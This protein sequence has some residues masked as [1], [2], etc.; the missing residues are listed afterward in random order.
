MA[1]EVVHTNHKTHKTESDQPRVIVESSLEE[2]YDDVVCIQWRGYLDNEDRELPKDIGQFH[3]P[4]RTYPKDARWFGQP[5][6]FQVAFVGQIKDWPNQE[7]IPA[8]M[9]AY[10]LNEEGWIVWVLNQ[11]ILL[12]Y[13]TGNDPAD[14]RLGPASFVYEAVL[15]A[16]QACGVIF[17]EKYTN[18]ELAA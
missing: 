9:E 15:L 7:A 6:T 11:S 1:K 14:K 12:E 5:E 4:L 13:E 16:D 2:G 10:R 17:P 18:L 8:I 3:F